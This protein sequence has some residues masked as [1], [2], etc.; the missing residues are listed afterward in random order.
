MDTKTRIVVESPVFQGVDERIAYR[1]DTTK[2]GSAVPT[3][4]AVALYDSAFVDVTATYMTGSPSASG[5]FIT[6][7]ALHSLVAG[8]QYRMEIKFVKDGN[9]LESWVDIYGQR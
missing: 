6:C 3:S 8:A 4:P 7:P 2:W 9:T 5:L 1:L